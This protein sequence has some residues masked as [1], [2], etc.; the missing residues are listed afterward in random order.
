MAPSAFAL[1][2]EAPSIHG[3]FDVSL[4]LKIGEDTAFAVDDAPG[5]SNYIGFEGEVGL[6]NGSALTYAFYE[7]V[8][9]DG[10]GFNGNYQS[11]VGYKMESM[12]VRGGNLDTP[13]RRVLDQ[14]DMFANTYA[15]ANNIFATN[16]TAANAA[17][18]LGGSETLSYAVSLD[19][20]N[21]N[22][23][24]PDSFDAIRIGAMVDYSISE[25]FSI[26]AGL[27][28]RDDVETNIGI[29]GNLT[30]EGGMGFVFGLEIADFEDQTGVVNDSA[31][32]IVVGGFMPMGE[33]GK[34]KGQIGFK[35][36]DADNRDA[37]TYL[38]VGY[39][40]QL[41]ES[42]TGYFLLTTG[43]DTGLNTTEQDVD[44]GATVLA[45][46]LKVSF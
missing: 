4:A 31:I 45:T 11:Y 43:M 20:S 18:L 29:S 38:A 39:D 24:D 34:F 41:A 44:G 16:T 26:A 15:D 22:A 19:F 23:S 14:A 30:T 6:D 13:L 12:E 37:A 17:M 7:N 42:V 25:S 28:V 8:S 3:S 40:Q 32:G 36:F 2:A 21:E 10:G 33:K 46:G 9:L 27:E 35:E 5:D 1:E